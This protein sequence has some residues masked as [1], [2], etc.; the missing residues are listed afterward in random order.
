MA[1][2]MQNVNSDFSNNVRRCQ[3]DDDSLQ[4]EK[5]DENKIQ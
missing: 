3:H 1:A 5:K 4:A 2:K